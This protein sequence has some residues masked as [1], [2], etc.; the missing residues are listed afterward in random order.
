MGLRPLSVDAL[1]ASIDDGTLPRALL[2]EVARASVE[3]WRQ[4]EHTDPLVEAHRIAA[5]LRRIRPGRVINATGVLLHTNLGRATLH[6]DA[7]AASAEAGAG[8]SAL[9]FDLTAGERGGRGEYAERLAA[10]LTASEDALVV[11]NNA[12]ALF[13]AMAALGAGRE[14]VV[15]R[16]EQIEIGG[17]FRLPELIAASGAKATEVGT[18]NRTRAKDYAK[19]IG[20]A[21]GALLKVHP[22]NYRI[23]G[24]TEETGYAELAALAHE[25]NVPLVADIGSGLLDARVPWLEGAPP[26]WLAGEPGARQVIEAGADLVLFSGDKLLGGPQAGIV[27]G[28]ADVIERLRG[29]PVAR[30]VRIGGPALAALSVTLEKYASGRG[31]EIPFWQMASTPYSQL[32]ARSSQVLAS[33]GVEGAVGEGQSVPGAG[34]VPGRGIPT[35]VITVLGAEQRWRRLLDALPP[36][37]ARR[38]AGQVVLDLRAVGEADDESV[39]SALTNAC[40]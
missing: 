38:E 35:P 23:E 1:A 13:L 20:S 5:G 12:G 29:H 33:S 11:N 7:V 2:I 16:G 32:E 10:A 14:I 39:A 21:T 6:L 26:A 24:F 9:E 31:S 3:A 25:R 22:S 30:A 36:V 40:R 28:S 19:A 18:T 17:A 15:S 27:V 4:D 37:V 8:F 34:T